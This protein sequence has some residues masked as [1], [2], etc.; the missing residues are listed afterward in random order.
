MIIAGVFAFVVG[1]VF[2]FASAPGAP[3][4][5][6]AAASSPGPSLPPGLMAP[7]TASLSPA[8]TPS[9]PT[10]APS[11]TVAPPIPVPPTPSPTPLTPEQRDALLLAE[12]ETFRTTEAV[13]GI[14]A[15]IEFAGG[16]RW[17]GVS[18]LA[19]VA[20][21]Q[22]VTA[23]TAFAVASVSK[24]FLSALTLALAN[25]G[26]LRLGDRA[27]Q[28][29]PGITIDKRITVRMLLDHTSGLGDFFL[30]PKI[31]ALLQGNRA[32]IW[33]VSESLRFVPKRLFVPG[34]DWA[35]SNTNYLLLGLIAERVGHASLAE[36]YRR[37]F[38]EPLDLS[39]TYYQVAEKPRGRVATAYRFEGTGKKRRPLPLT[40]GTGIAPFRSVVT[41]AGGAAPL[42]STSG[43]LAHWA[44]ALY[45]GQVLDPASTAAISADVVATA[46]FKPRL[47][48]GLGAQAVAVDGLATLGHSGRLLGTRAVMRYFT[49]SGISIAVVSNQ[50]RTDLGPLVARLAVIAVPGAI[51]PRPVH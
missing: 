9:Q 49:A 17:T 1:A 50:S 33:T 31:D 2:A 29:L 19:N 45:G 47:P 11:P 3:S 14:A 28:Y 34:K 51:P 30:N 41:A 40:D 13:P 22:P 32:R 39:R 48:Y 12:L 24:T 15:T 23:N 21:K 10:G 26:R 37:R 7:P 36:Q 5:G 35:Y 4:P 27:Y 43:D 6:V 16:T 18:G 8:V 42:A 25:E 44:R 20:R 46:R 38:I